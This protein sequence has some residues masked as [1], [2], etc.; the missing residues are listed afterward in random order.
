M[1]TSGRALQ[2]A[3]S[4]CPGAPQAAARSATGLIWPHAPQSLGGGVQQV[5]QR[6]PAVL[7]AWAGRTLMARGVRPV[8]GRSGELLVRGRLL[9]RAPWT[10]AYVYAVPCG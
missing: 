4:V 8:P 10:G 1:R 3:R 9:T 5:R 7:F 2:A 6:G